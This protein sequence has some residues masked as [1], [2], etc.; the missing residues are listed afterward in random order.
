M[1]VRTGERARQV[2]N[3]EE[4]GGGARNRRETSSLWEVWG[5]D[6]LMWFYEGSRR[7]RAGSRI[8]EERPLLGRVMTQKE[9]EIDSK[10]RQ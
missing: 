2:R 10:E 6:V 9:K 7:S 5:N 1:H 8:R 4:G 3:E